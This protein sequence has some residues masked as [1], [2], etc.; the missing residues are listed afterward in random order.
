MF[1]LPGRW[2]WILMELPG[3]LTVLYVVSTLPTEL[4]IAELPWQ[5]KLMATLFVLIPSTLHH[6]SLIH[7]V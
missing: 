6:L 4:N 3:F 7:R 2:A 5:N 1:D